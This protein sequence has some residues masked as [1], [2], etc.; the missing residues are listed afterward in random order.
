MEFSMT[1]SSKMYLAT[2]FHGLRSV[3]ISCM[4]IR[5]NSLANLSMRCGMALFC[6]IYASYIILPRGDKLI[7]YWKMHAEFHNSRV[8]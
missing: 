4:N 3:D 7:A 1:L 2:P 5:R 8:F 6:I